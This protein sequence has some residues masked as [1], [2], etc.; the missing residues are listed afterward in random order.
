M[1]GIFFRVRAGAR[2]RQDEGTQHGVRSL[3]L[4]LAGLI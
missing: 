2:A 1:G 4:Q 3:Q